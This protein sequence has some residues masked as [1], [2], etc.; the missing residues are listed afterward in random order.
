MPSFPNRA[1]S[2]DITASVPAVQTARLV[3]AL[4]SAALHRENR[5]MAITTARSTPQ[6]CG[7]RRA[8]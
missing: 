4:N 5:N 7:Y 2:H 8:L 3:T 6:Y 1:L